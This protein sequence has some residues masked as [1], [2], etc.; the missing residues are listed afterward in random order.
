MG[1]HHSTY[2][3]YGFEIP[4][5]IG[6]D[7]ID[8]ALGEE[9]NDDPDCVGYT[10]VG[11]WDKA[12]LCTRYTVVEENAVV[13]LTADTLAQPERLAA[14]ETAL[15]DVAVRLGCPDHPAPAWLVIHDHS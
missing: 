10:I 9:R 7:D 14:W 1:L 2:V 3:A 4:T 15:H 12:L 13:R 8:R 11:D 5:S 6:L